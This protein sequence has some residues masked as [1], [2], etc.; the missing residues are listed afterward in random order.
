MESIDSNATLAEAASWLA[1]C[2]TLP[3][4]A[5]KLTGVTLGE[6]AFRKNGTAKVCPQSHYA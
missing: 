6:R 3:A 2:A 4:D 5:V 1:R